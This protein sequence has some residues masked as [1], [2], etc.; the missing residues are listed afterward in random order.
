MAV[1]FDSSAA[2]NAANVSSLTFSHTCTGTGTTGLLLVCLETVDA[3]GRTISSAT[4][5]GVAMTQVPT[6]SPYTPAAGRLHYMFYLLSPTVGAHN[7]VLTMTGA[8]SN[9]LVAASTSYTGVKQTGFPDASGQTF[10]ASTPGSNL[11]I[12]ITS[13]ASGCWL[14]GFGTAEGSGGVS[15]GTSTTERTSS[16]YGNCFVAGFDSNGTVPSGSNSLMFHSA[17]T[18]DYMTWLAVSIAPVSSPAVTSGD[19]LMFM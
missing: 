11:S 18:T 10:N 1:A 13:V 16:A 7:I 6:I 19:F 14:T 2:G 15:A 3:N 9:N 17:T 4:Y 12:S 8:V 5:N